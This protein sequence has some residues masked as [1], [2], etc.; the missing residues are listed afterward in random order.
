MT[1][2][3]LTNDYVVGSYKLAG[4]L[5]SR[6]TNWAL[7]N[8]YLKGLDKMRPDPPKGGCFRDLLIAYVNTFP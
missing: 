5:L 1:V 7:P 2:W 6:T 3:G 4:R 8:R